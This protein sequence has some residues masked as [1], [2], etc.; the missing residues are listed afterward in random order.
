MRNEALDKRLDSLSDDEIRLVL[1]FRSRQTRQITP[2]RWV[3][4]I[5]SLLATFAILVVISIAFIQAVEIKNNGV[6]G[7]IPVPLSWVTAITNNVKS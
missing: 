5:L 1:Q 2:A 3:A 6:I 7:E 4:R